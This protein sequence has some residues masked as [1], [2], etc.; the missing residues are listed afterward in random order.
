MGAAAMVAT[1]T[2]ERRTLRLPISHPGTYAGCLRAQRCAL[3]DGSGGGS[4]S[5]QNQQTPDHN[6]GLSDGVNPTTV[7]STGCLP[8]S[9]MVIARWGTAGIGDLLPANS[10][11]PE[12][13][14]IFQPAGR[15]LGCR[16][17][18]SAFGLCGLPS[19]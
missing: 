4:A 10:I 5:F 1:Q 2:G 17:R 13:A 7:M 8:S 14:R 12:I 6:N 3:A 19:P 9:I 18:A 15:D 11:A 16:W